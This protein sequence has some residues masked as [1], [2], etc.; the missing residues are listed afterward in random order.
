MCLGSTHVSLCVQMAGSMQSLAHEAALA[1]AN[2]A[3][4]VSK[5]IEAA[6][7]TRLG[8][9]ADVSHHVCLCHPVYMLHT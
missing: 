5:S 1:A 7:S 2:R 9:V 6:T 4:N 8:H 3:G